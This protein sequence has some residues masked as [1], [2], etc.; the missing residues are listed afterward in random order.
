[1]IELYTATGQLLG[2]LDCAAIDAMYARGEPPQV[3]RW[4]GDRIFCRESEEWARF[5]EC[6]Q[7]VITDTEDN[8]LRL[9]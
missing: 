3:L 4:G 5:Y 7:W 6:E 8:R 1:M 9:T 2:H